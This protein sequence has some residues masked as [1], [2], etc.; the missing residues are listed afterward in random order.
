MGQTTVAITSSHPEILPLT[1]QFFDGLEMS[2]PVSLELKRDHLGRFWVI[3][4]TIGRTDFWVGL[5]VA[6]KCNL[7]HTEYLHCLGHEPV[8]EDSFTPTIWFDSERDVTAYARHVSKTLPWSKDKFKVTFSYLT[9][10][11]LKPFCRAFYQSIQKVTRS[12]VRRF[13]NN[14][15]VTSVKGHSQYRVSVFTE[16]DLLPDSFKRLLKENVSASIFGDY[17]WYENFCEQ[18]AN[19]DGEPRFYCLTDQSD[20]PLGLLPLWLQQKRQFGMKV[21]YLTSLANYYSPIFDL[22]FNEHLISRGRALEQLFLYLHGSSAEWDFM[23]VFPVDEMTKDEILS[24]SKQNHLAAESYCMTKNWF[25]KIENGYQ[26]YMDSI[27]SKTKNTIKRKRSKLDKNTDW[28]INIYQKP[29]DVSQALED[30]HE[31]YNHS[32]KPVEPYPDFLNG[33]VQSA[34]ENSWLRLG[35]LSIDNVAVAV[36][37]WLVANNTANIYKLAYRKDARQYSPGTILTGHLVQHTLVEDKVNKID[38]L[39]G[40]DD[41]KKDWMTSSRDLYGIQITNHS[42]FKS[43]VLGLRNSLSLYKDK[44]LNKR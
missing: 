42:H 10:N 35:V 44:L 27:P 34:A 24:S 1:E 4:P 7:L 41:F 19:L 17:S 11:D 39:T 31:V 9:R 12:L 2:G 38:F 43:I 32:W 26:E 37:L 21:N 33:L 18:V 29:E 40:K 22:V 5:C 23:H 28:E 15:N 8:A 16:L 3:E 20:Q 6:A 25:E 36:Q 30:Y 14:A 13:D